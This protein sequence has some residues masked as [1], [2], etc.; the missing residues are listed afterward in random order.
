MGKKPQR[1]KA[2]FIPAGTEPPPPVDEDLG[3]LIPLTTPGLPGEGFSCLDVDGWDDGGVADLS[4]IIDLDDLALRRKKGDEAYF[5]AKEADTLPRAFEGQFK[6]TTRKSQ[7]LQLAQ[8]L[9]AE[10]S[11]FVCLFVVV[12][13]WCVYSCCLSYLLGHFKPHTSNNSTNNSTPPKKSNYL[14]TT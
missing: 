6:N 2:T 14:T 9:F 3:S 11:L 12:M 5:E 8:L 7:K 4:L 1:K 13:S 10:V